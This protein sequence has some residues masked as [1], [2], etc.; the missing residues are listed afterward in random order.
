MNLGR[1]IV[2]FFE[3]IVTPN[4]YKIFG[5]TKIVTR[6]IHNE[7]KR[8][9]KDLEERFV[10]ENEKRLKA[11]AEVERLERKNSEHVDKQQVSEKVVV[12]DK[13]FDNE[14]ELRFILGR[15]EFDKKKSDIVSLFS[16]IKGSSVYSKGNQVAEYA[17][18]LGLIELIHEEEERLEYGLTKIGYIVADKFNIDISLAS[19]IEKL[20]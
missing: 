3:R 11:Q 7:L 18:S 19:R 9:L 16:G 10:E 13:G 12:N 2:E 14:T 4:I 5:N 8:E 15:I 1:L 6:A 17:L 20:I